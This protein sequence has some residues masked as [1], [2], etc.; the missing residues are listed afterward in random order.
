MYAEIF[1]SCLLEFLLKNKTKQKSLIYQVEQCPGQ[2]WVKIS[3]FRD[4]IDSSWTLSQTALS[5]SWELSWTGMIQEEHF[6]G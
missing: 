6:P 4:R 2:R 1:H 3:A 5:E